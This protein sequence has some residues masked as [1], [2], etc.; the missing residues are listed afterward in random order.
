MAGGLDYVVFK[1]PFCPKPFYDSMTS[2][3]HLVTVYIL[4]DYTVSCFTVTHYNIII[5]INFDLWK[6]SKCSFYYF[7]FRKH[8]ITLFTTDSLFFIFSCINISC[9]SQKPEAQTCDKE[10]WVVYLHS[11]GCVSLLLLT[12]YDKKSLEVK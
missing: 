12:F 1:G 4:L 6:Y 8:R 11:F 7:V 2:I 10:Y 5:I 9:L 3:N